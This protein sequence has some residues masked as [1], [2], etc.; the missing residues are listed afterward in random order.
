MLEFIDE[1]LDSHEL[2]GDK[3]IGTPESDDLAEMVRTIVRAA[4]ARKAENIVA[5]RV[6]KI[7]TVTSFLVIVTGNSRPQNRAIA[8][9]VKDDVQEF[10]GLLPGSTGVPEG[11][12]ES[13]WIV[14]DYGS[15]MVH[16]MTPKSR[17]FYNVEGQWRNKGG[18]YMNLADVVLPNTV[19][20][21]AATTAGTMQGIA[22]EDDP[23]W[24]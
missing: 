3:T 10:Y 18:E 22:K 2:V 11:S 13:G 8:A 9:S 12:P 14:L 20:E 19:G 4:D 17:L 5:L 24:S 16:V 21:N 7:S 6:S 1:P 15:V 23:F